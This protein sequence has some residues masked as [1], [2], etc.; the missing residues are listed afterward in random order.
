MVHL[1]HHLYGVD[2]PVN[3]IMKYISQRLSVQ[4]LHNAAVTHATGWTQ[5]YSKCTIIRWFVHGL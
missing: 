2:D 1:I 3:N 5:K 4:P